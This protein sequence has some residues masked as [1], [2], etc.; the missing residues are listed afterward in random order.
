MQ[1]IERRHGAEEA[2]PA[3]LRG[4]FGI[5]HERCVCRSEVKDFRRG[6][7][8]VSSAGSAGGRGMAWSDLS[9]WVSFV[10][11]FRRGSA[12]SLSTV[13]SHMFH[14]KPLSCVVSDKVPTL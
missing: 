7:L 14:Q 8:L 3:A 1:E 4:P 12:G 10:D 6:F 2:G 13:V 9:R 11:F 5:T